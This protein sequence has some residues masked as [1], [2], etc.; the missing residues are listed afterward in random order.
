MDIYDLCIMYRNKTR[1]EILSAYREMD[2]EAVD[3]SSGDKTLLHTAAA[4][5][6]PE[7]VR[8]LLE[9]GMSA[10]A[11]DRYG[12]FP[13]HAL[14]APDHVRSYRS[15]GV[16]EEEV[17][18]CA[19]LLFEA[20]ASTMRKNEDGLPALCDAAKFARYEILES[21]AA[22]GL[23]L[24]MTDRDGNNPLHAACDW[25][26]H[27]VNYIDRGKEISEDEQKAGY[28]R[29]IRVLVDAGMDIDEKNDFGM[30]A[31]ELAMDSGVKEAAAVL[32]G[33]EA[34]AATGGMTVFQAIEKN[35]M[36]SLRALIEGGTDLDETAGEGKFNGMTPLAA[37]C[38]MLHMDAVQLLLEGG[39]DPNVKNAD[40]ETCLARLLK[41]GDSEGEPFWQKNDNSLCKKLLK[42]L[43][44]A[45][46][47]K[48]ARVNDHA[49]TALTLACRKCWNSGQ[50]DYHFVNA[51]VDGGCDV[52]LADL[53]GVTP[54]MLVSRFGDEND[55]Q[56]SILEAGAD[57]NAAD[58]NGDTAL[59]YAA[60][61]RSDN[62]AKEMAEMLF[63]FGF[64]K[65]DAVNNEGK[66]ALELA[67]E[68]NNEPLVKLI[69]MNS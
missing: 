30:T 55:L 14:A 61:N 15:G 60:R 46:M 12:N 54:L 67:T 25:L 13:L 32:T 26:G 63:E 3:Q 31:L 65:T 10:N 8:L 69:L 57:L 34:M 33:D 7:A 18:A 49:D 56:I 24:T 50:M 42:L 47:E 64:E 40:G 41:A 27:P 39:A 53:D 4:L 5:A 20:G 38:M 2:I 43:W 66:T 36:D 16:T 21:A 51:L 29:C 45:G 1:E 17:R 35:D 9:R 23:K 6:D 22:H 68:A 11:K 48:D 58:R 19:D 28:L 44:A 62:A 59:C 37:A 52:N